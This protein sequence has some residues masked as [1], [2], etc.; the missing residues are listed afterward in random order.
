MGEYCGEEGLVETLPGSGGVLASCYISQGQPTKKPN[1]RRYQETARRQGGQGGCKKDR[2]TQITQHKP[3]WNCT[4]WAAG[5]GRLGRGWTWGRQSQTKVGRDPQ[6]GEPLGVDRDL[7]TDRVQQRGGKRMRYTS[8]T[9]IQRGN[10]GA[11]RDL[12]GRSRKGR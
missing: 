7:I 10:P 5:Q 11:G 1:T 4:D 6:K 9:G 8:T 12:G 3:L 2:G